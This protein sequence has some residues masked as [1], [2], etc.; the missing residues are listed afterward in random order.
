MDCEARG[1]GAVHIIK[2]ALQPGNN[3]LQLLFSKFDYEQ[4]RAIQLV[5]NKNSIKKIHSE[6]RR[7][8]PS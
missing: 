8:G 4:R 2:L 7:I 6:E 5:S 1:G 3:L